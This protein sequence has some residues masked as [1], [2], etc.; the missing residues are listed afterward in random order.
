MTVY[1]LATDP[2]TPSTLYA[3]TNGYVC[4][5]TDS[6]ATWKAMSIGH[7]YISVHCLA[8]DPITP[9]TVYAG[10]NVDV[11]RSTDSGVTWTVVKLGIT[12][13]N[14]TSLAIDPKTPATLY[15]SFTHNGV[16]RYVGVSPYALTTTASPAAGGSIDRSPDASSYAPGTVVTLTASPVAGYVFTGWSGALSGTKNPATVTMD[17]DKIVTASFAVDAKRIIELK[18]GS[19]TMLVDGRPVV[20]EAAPIILN[21][22]TLLP[23]RALIE[24]LGGEVLWSPSARTVD[25]FLGERSVDV[26]VGGNIG[27]VNDK[28][29]AIDP[30]NPK[31]VPVI[32]GSR[33]FLPLRF[34]AEALALDIQ[35]NATTEA[36]TITYTP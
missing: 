18:I 19:S 28:A 13:R 12:S 2:L 20:L 10:T 31:V 35:W 11:F 17:A 27:Y 4:R 5:S 14:V 36:I 16:F 15:A 33:A 21:S 30:A 26:G 6:G 1:S 7:D 34:V 23:I 24:T 22:R 29:V 25:V 32:I 8:I 3:G 9:S